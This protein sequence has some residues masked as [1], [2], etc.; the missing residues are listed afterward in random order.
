MGSGHLF[1]LHEG[2]FTRHTISNFAERLRAHQHGLPGVSTYRLRASWIV[3]HLN[4]GTPLDVLRQ[5]AGT[6]TMQALLR[7]ERWVLPAEPARGRAALRG[8]SR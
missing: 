4:D 6:K 7:Y 8:K 1:Q 2:R 3:S 5:A